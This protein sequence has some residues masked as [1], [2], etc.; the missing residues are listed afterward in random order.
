[1]E[2]LHQIRGVGGVSS[3]GAGGCARAEQLSEG[4]DVGAFRT[5]RCLD[6]RSLAVGIEQ[7][8]LLTYSS[9]A[10]SRSK[11]IMSK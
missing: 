3:H 4:M 5:A 1:M 8:L 2:E 9:D 10:T 6:K 11:D 7:G